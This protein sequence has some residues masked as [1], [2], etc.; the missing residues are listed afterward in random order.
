MDLLCYCKRLSACGLKCIS[1][2]KLIYFPLH[3]EWSTHTS[4]DVT[5]LQLTLFDRADVSCVT[6][7]SGKGS[8]YDAMVIYGIITETVKYMKL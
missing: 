3:Y 1:P 2:I 6:A 4:C 8:V 7:F 5:V